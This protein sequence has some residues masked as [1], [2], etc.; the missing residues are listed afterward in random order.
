M[1]QESGVMICVTAFV[2][3]LD[4]SLAIAITEIVV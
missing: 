1:R 3:I 4:Y 2:Y